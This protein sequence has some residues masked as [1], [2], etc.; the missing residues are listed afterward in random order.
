MEHQKIN[1]LQ[2][3]P[4]LPAGLGIIFRQPARTDDRVLVPLRA[5]LDGD[6]A[7]SSSWDDLAVRLRAKGFAL[8]DLGHGADLVDLARGERLCS[9]QELGFG[10]DRLMQRLGADLRA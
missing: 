8:I 6:L 1:L 5:L 7:H 2:S 4:V 10:Y 9:G 3:V